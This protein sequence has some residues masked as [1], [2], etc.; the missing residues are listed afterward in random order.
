MTAVIFAAHGLSAT[1]M[2]DSVEMVI[3]PQSSFHV[4]MLSQEEGIEPFK[5]TLSSLTRRLVIDEQQQILIL[6]D[7]PAGT[8]Y[9]LGVQLSL[10]YDGIS[11]LSGTNFSMVLTA[12]EMTDEPLEEVTR[13]VIENGREAINTFK[14]ITA[15]EEDF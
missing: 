4:V 12:L 13:Q 5:N 7:I 10:E 2:Q 11:V 15:V 9:N 14:D 3:G 6:T 1:G 8:P